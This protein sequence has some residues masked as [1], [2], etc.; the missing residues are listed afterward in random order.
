MNFNLMAVL[1]I[2]ASLGLL[3]LSIASTAPTMTPF[4]NGEKCISEQTEDG[5]ITSTAC[6]EDRN[7]PGLSGDAK[8][9]CR[10]SG[11]KCSSSQTGFGE[12]DNFK[13]N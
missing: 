5:G 7:D 13:P 6:P 12:F 8:K 9:E 11:F 10:E 4:A 1:V 3:T 2:V